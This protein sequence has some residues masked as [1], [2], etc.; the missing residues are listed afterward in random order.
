MFARLYRT[1]ATSQGGDKALCTG[2]VSPK[3]HGGQPEDEVHNDDNDDN[4]DNARDNVAREAAQ[5]WPMPPSKV[6]EDTD[7][8]EIVKV[9]RRDPKGHSNH[10]QQCGWCGK[11][12]SGNMKK[13]QVHLACTSHGGVSIAKCSVANEHEE[14]KR[15]FWQQMETSKLKGKGPFS[16]LMSQSSKRPAV[17][18]ATGKGKRQKQIRDLQNELSN[19]RH[20][21]S[22]LRGEPRAS[23]VGGD[24]EGSGGGSAHGKHFNTP[25]E[26]IVTTLEDEDEDGDGLVNVTPS[27]SKPILQNLIYDNYKPDLEDVR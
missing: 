15:I 5:V 1:A 26:G 13:A 14:V 17:G 10:L 27:S 12:F 24:V 19:A 21:I 11:E 22:T 25:V 16:Q 2:T 7:V 4:D 9:L 3:P 6:K 8:Y 18:N 23:D 20:V